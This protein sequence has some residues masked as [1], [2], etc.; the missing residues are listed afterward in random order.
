[1]YIFFHSGTASWASTFA[2]FIV[3]IAQTIEDD[4]VSLRVGWPNIY[5]MGIVEGRIVE[6]KIYKLIM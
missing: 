2:N 1:M 3:L 4:R 5:L 6:L